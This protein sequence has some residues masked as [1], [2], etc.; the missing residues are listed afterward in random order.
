MYVCVCVCVCMWKGREGWHGR[1]VAAQG[2][3]YVCTCM[4]VY[5]YVKGSEG[6]YKFI[7]EIIFCVCM[8][9]SIHVCM[10]VYICM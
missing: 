3:P 6:L 5:A 1:Q 7:P 10:G 9:V 4:Y 2:G 8:Y